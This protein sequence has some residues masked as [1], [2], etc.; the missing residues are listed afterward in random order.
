VGAVQLTVT[1]VAPTD[2]KVAAP[3]AVGAVI[4]LLAEED[5][6][7]PPP[8]E[9]RTRYQYVVFAVLPVSV[10]LVAVVTAICVQGPVEAA[11]RSSL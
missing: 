11:A 3:G 10:R 5:G 9:A 7:S 1:A 2:G 4:A 6:P 8:F